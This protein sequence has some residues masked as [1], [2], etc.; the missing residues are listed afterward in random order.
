[1]YEKAFKARK[2]Y[3][4]QKNTKR[5]MR[6]WVVSDKKADYFLLSMTIYTGVVSMTE[7]GRRP[8]SGAEY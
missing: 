5:E 7:L 1:M 2:S 3:T 4:A 8:G 6:F